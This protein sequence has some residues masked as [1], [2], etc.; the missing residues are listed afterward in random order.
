MLLRYLVAPNLKRLVATAAVN[1]RVVCLWRVARWLLAS[2][3]A[4]G[5]RP[6]AETLCSSTACRDDATSVFVSLAPCSGFG[7]TPPCLYALLPRTRYIEVGSFDE[8]QRD[9][10]LSIFCF[11]KL[12]VELSWSLGPSLAGGFAATKLVSD[13]TLKLASSCS[14]LAVSPASS[15]SLRCLPQSLAC[16][17][18]TSRFDDS[19]LTPRTLAF[20]DRLVAPLSTTSCLSSC[21]VRDLSSCSP[22]AWFL[23]SPSRFA[24]SRLS[25]LAFAPNVALQNVGLGLSLVE[26]G[27]L[28]SK[29]FCKLAP[30]LE[31]TSCSI[32]CARWRLPCSGLTYVFKRSVSRFEALS[33]GRV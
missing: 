23:S 32:S 11:K 30:N 26:V 31:V 25:L 28:W 15:S 8:R 29:P 13:A 21:R 4:S 1:Q 5:G 16:S 12:G 33:L 9:S 10:A 22:L 17:F 3:T 14:R 19:W 20:G 7:K 24:S 6:H 27:C 18:C 2:S